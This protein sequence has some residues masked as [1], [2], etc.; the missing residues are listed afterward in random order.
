MKN[1][2][3]VLT[4]VLI[5]CSLAITGIV[6]TFN[7]IANKNLDP[8]RQE[9]RKVLGQDLRFDRLEVTLF[10]T[11]GFS[12]KEF[13]V[14]DDPRFAAT[15]IIR[16]K[17]L[18][19][20]LSLWN[21]LWGR[22][23]ID[24]LIFKEPELQVITD[25][26]GSLNLTNLSSR[27]RD[28]RSFPKLHPATPE[29]RPSAV[30]FS[31]NEIRVKNGRIEY[32]DRSVKEPA[33]LRA[34]NI[35]MVIKGFTSSEATK[36]SFAASLTEGL[37]QDVRVNGEI[38]PG[39]DGALWSQRNIAINIRFDSLHVPVIARAIASLRDV[40]P[41]ELDV[42]GPM[43]LQANASGSLA[44]PRIN[45]I[46]L[47]VPLFGSS[48]YNAVATGSI[49]FSERRSW[50][51]AQF[52]GEVKVDSVPVNRLRAL[53]FL[54]SAFAPAVVTEGTVSLTSR[55]IGT[56]NTVR[57]GAL[58]IADKAEFRIGEWLRKPINIPAVVKTRISRQRQRLLLHESELVVGQTRIGFSGSVASE[59]EPRLQLVAHGEQ[60]SVARWN[61]LLSESAFLAIAGR[62][63][64][65]I[66]IDK[67]LLPADGN[68]SVGGKFNL[69]DAE[70]KHKN[71][72][73][74]IERL[75]AAVSFSGKQASLD[76]LTFRVG[77]STFIVTGN[78][79]NILEPRLNYRLRAAQLI[80]AD[81]PAWIESPPLVLKNLSGSGQLLVEK[82]QTVLTGKFGAPEGRYQRFDFHDFRS[83]IEWSAV[84]LAF[85]NLSLRMFDGT[86][87][88]EGGWSS[89]GVNS[90]EFRIS[91][92]ADGIDTRFIIA[93]LIPQLKDRFAGR[94][95]GR[96]QFDTTKSGSAAGEETVRGSGE[97]LIDRG[98][99][100]DF[101]LV[102][103][104]LLRGS[105]ASVSDQTSSRL[106]PGF[107]GLINRQD[108][109]FDSIKA[110]FLVE[111]E[112]VLTD[113]LVI[114]TP[115]YTITGAGWVGFDR[116]TK[117]NGLLLLSPRLT[118]EVQRD[119]RI[120]RYLLDRRGRLSVSFRLE[121]TIP[122][123][124]I[125]LDNRLL[126]Q[127]LRGGTPQRG[128]GPDAEDGEPAGGGKNWLPDALERFLNR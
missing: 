16:T 110:T 34:Q 46:N 73:R 22:I 58:I 113:D 39:A 24:S 2:R 59:P 127:A 26:A 91:S 125:R 76:Q 70:F 48:E 49:D 18:V 52:E 54:Q 82:G 61:P 5:A 117:W 41:R 99:I 21:L 128:S 36:V 53:P 104:L 17:E 12:A 33:E 69:A 1:P 37:N 60:S 28:L 19:L 7:V 116:S 30:G 105:G 93:Q 84:S 57:I 87:R 6:Q 85:R 94:L 68:W 92:Q 101:N 107:A 124:K 47:K 114:T 122:N 102:S 23:V 126:A 98:A 63:D 83:E 123:V 15:P 51:A 45:N 77:A 80:L 13:R 3:K 95:S 66:V 88:S 71:S 38:A 4:V 50:D 109:P 20:G 111:E 120:I 121:G 40:I 55:F 86:F 43:S 108:T 89:S 79:A 75:N 29:P 72:G 67:R 97:T 112:R 103:Q 106:P 64:W 100:K 35:D 81:L 119:Y 74:K 118:Q 56:W 62:A 14:A 8:V 25:E 42:T 27:K 96:A 44:R 9:L 10:F 115:D 78:A 65:Q 90:R 32:L 11:P 31:I